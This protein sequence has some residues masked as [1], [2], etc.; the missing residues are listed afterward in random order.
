PYSRERLTDSGVLLFG[1]RSIQNEAFQ[2]GRDVGAT[3]YT[4]SGPLVAGLGI[5]TGG[6]RDVPTRYLP[7]TLGVPMVVLRAGF[8]GGIGEDVFAMPTGQPVPDG[9]R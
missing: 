7:Q 6:G 1:D 9:A 4:Q 3:F 2:V 8:D 5:F